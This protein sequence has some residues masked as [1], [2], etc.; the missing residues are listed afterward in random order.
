MRGAQRSLD[1]EAR[2]LLGSRR[3][4][5][6]RRRPEGVFVNR[7][8]SRPVPRIPGL[9]AALLA[10]LAGLAAAPPAEASPETLKRSVSNIL[11]GPLDVVFAPVV[12]SRT[13]YHNIQD[14]DDSMGVRIAY[15]IPGVVWN[16]TLQ[17]GSG[18]IRV[19][20]G[21]LEFVP[22]L[23]LLPFEAD[24]DPLFSPVEKSDALVDEDTPVLNVKFGVT[25]V[26]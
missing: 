8:R 20:T 25:Y 13:V 19:F 14:I 26:E 16:T 9:A 12:G 5:R 4:R 3:A 1:K 22:G 21:L 2:G 6:A 10:L 24:L 17:A 15:V 18:I 11:F 7:V 23:G